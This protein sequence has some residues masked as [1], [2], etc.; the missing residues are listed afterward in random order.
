[1]VRAVK[2]THITEEEET[3]LLSVKE[4]PHSVSQY[5]DRS[6]DERC[7]NCRRFGHKESQY[8]LASKTKAV[9]VE[10]PARKV[11]IFIFL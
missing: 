3:S 9:K 4:K 5:N 8:I 10:T 6:K 2:P 1:V 11:S 7:S